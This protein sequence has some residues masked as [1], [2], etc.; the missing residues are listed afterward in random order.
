MWVDL[1]TRR[2][3]ARQASPL[4]R[5]ASTRS[6]PP[7]RPARCRGRACRPAPGRG[8]VARRARPPG[9]PPR[10]RAPRRA[11][12]RR[13]RAGRAR[14]CSCR[15]RPPSAAAARAP[16]PPRRPPSRGSGAGSFVSRSRTSS[17]ASI[18]PRPRTSPTAAKRS[19]PALHARADRRAD[20]L[21]ALDEAAPPR[22][23][24]AR[25][26]AAAMATGLPTYVPPI[27]L[28]PGAFM[29]AARPITPESGSPP[30]IDFATRHQVRL[31]AEVLHREHRG[32]CGRSRSAPRRRPARCR[33]RRRA[34]QALD[35]LDRRDDEAALALHRLE[36]DRRHVL[37]GD[38]RREGAL[39]LARAPSPR[40]GR[41]TGSGTARGR[42]RARTGRSR[43][44]TG[45]SSTSGS[46]PSASGRGSRRRRRSRPAGRW[47]RARS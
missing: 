39:E 12:R 10:P 23:R 37:G 14:G 32:R 9:T 16:R 35:E 24:R 21:R 13:S 3:R 27:A 38:A 5:C 28:S 47:R 8:H 20:R 7:R 25:R 41:G 45:A 33:A 22:S 17:I 11:R 26:C 34:A 44:C 31:D 1:S 4:H 29:S 18:A 19:L 6:A 30:A 2:R 40:R 36:D 15:R 43:P 46:S 42:P